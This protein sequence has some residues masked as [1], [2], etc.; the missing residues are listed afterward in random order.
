LDEARKTA[1]RR[2]KISGTGGGGPFGLPQALRRWRR[3]FLR[4]RVRG[5]LGAGRS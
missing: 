5:R 3:L 1:I 4:G 2:M